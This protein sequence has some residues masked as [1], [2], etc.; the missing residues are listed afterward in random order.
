MKQ[1]YI[2]YSCYAT[3]GMEPPVKHQ[4][5]CSLSQCSLRQEMQTQKS[6]R[7]LAAT[8][9]SYKVL[10]AVQCL[11]LVSFHNIDWLTVID[12]LRI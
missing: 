3:Q 12:N 11:F 10:A 1:A 8:Q 9:K 2:M 6:Y 4:Y 7:V 5:C